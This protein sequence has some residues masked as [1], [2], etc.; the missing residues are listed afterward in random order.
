MKPA[1]T[2][3]Y[4]HGTTLVELIMTILVVSISLAGVLSVIQINSR[5]SADPMIQHQVTA[6]AEAYLEE[7]MAKEFT[8]PDGPDVGG[9][10]VGETRTTYDDVND[11]HGLA[12]TGARDQNNNVISGLEDYTVAV[13]VTSETLGGIAA[14]Y[15]WRVQVTVTPPRGDAITIS[16]YRTNY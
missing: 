16:S 2:R 8:D 14:T 9:P 12:D 7:I 11:Y 15:V 6:I 13:T 1:E 4:L 3:S 10:E 5:T